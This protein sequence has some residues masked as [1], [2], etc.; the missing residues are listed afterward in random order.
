VAVGT[1]LAGCT[2]AEPTPI[3]P[4]A[5]TSTSPP[6]S[7]AP[8]SPTATPGT[9][10]P[11]AP[12]P[13]AD[14]DDVRVRT[15]V[16]TVRTLAGTLGPRPCTSPTYFSAART[17]ESQFVELGWQVHRQRFRVPAGASVA[18]PTEGVPVRGGRSVN[19]VA[20]RGDVRPGEPWLLVGAH[21]DTVPTG[22]G[23]EDNA[24][25][26]GVLLATAEAL[27]GHR[28][29]L[30]VVLVAFGCEEPRGPGDDDHQFGSRS[31]VAS[32][33]ER[34]RRSLA[35]MVALDRVGV[36]DVVPLGSVAPGDPLLGELERAAERAGV[37]VVTESGQRSSDHWSF[38][39]A[40]L[41]GVRV[42]STPYAE[43]HSTHDVPSVVD[44]AQ[45]E[46]TARLIVAWLAG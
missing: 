31:Y 30:P 39:R 11:A 24:S 34:R 5:P 29:R 32:L 3:R 38:V 44:P 25:G 46:R 16:T 2:G 42:G 1:V 9:A 18:G 22:P 13:R 8:P 12:L 10:P 37:P 41:P 27:A 7:P 45:L 17:V 14:P 19:L 21:L 20:T 33:G 26:V 6:A 36:G 35:G 4:V 15:A 23:A 40:G 43:Y 28:A